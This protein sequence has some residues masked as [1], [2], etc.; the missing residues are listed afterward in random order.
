MHFCSKNQWQYISIIKPFIILFYSKLL[1]FIQNFR[2]YMLFIIT[3]ILLLIKLH[4]VIAVFYLNTWGWAESY[5]LMV[6]Q[7]HKQDWTQ[8]LL[9][10]QHHRSAFVIS[11]SF[12]HL[13]F[14]IFLTSSLSPSLTCSFIVFFLNITRPFLIFWKYHSTLTFILSFLSTR[15]FLS[16]FLSFFLFYPILSFFL[17]YLPYSFFLSFLPVH[18]FIFSV[19]LNIT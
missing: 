16:F 19:F 3:I 7:F 2:I 10:D 6:F 12:S 15:F 9:F 13:S 5:Y 14:F 11:G 17:L 18:L 8:W 1:L 4:F